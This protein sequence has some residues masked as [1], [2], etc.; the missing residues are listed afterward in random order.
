MKKLLFK[1]MCMTSKF[2]DFHL[3]FLYFLTFNIHQQINKF[4]IYAY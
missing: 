4:S 3:L 2:F 1:I